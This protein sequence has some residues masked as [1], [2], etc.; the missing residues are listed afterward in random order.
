MT[1]WVRESRSLSDVW[2]YPQAQCLQQHICVQMRHQHAI[3]SANTLAQT[4]PQT[5]QQEH[6]NAHVLYATLCNLQSDLLN[7]NLPKTGS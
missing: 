1:W 5:H 4:V 3:E 2:Q 7:L 6:A